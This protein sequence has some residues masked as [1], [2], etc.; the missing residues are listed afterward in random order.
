[1]NKF[2][3]SAIKIDNWLPW[4][5]LDSEHLRLLR[6]V[7]ILG[8]PLS[9]LT[10]LSVFVMLGSEELWC[11]GVGNGAASDVDWVGVLG[12]DL[13]IGIFIGVFSNTNDKKI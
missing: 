8:K 1:M 4:S 9:L 11:S 13:F 7:I 12:G 6:C 3:I 5:I 10:A 2:L